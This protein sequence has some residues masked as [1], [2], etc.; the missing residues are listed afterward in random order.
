MRIDVGRF[1]Q[2]QIPVVRRLFRRSSMQSV[3]ATPFILFLG[4]LF[5]EAGKDGD[6]RGVGGGERVKGEGHRNGGE[7][8]VETFLIIPASDQWAV[9]E[10]L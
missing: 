1:T 4:V 2:E 9:L 8:D 10:D 5:D 3:P 6:G 7:G